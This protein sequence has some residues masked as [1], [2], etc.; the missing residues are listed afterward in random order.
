M[1][2]IKTKLHWS[3]DINQEIQKD[4][5]FEKEVDDIFKRYLKCDWG[6][7]P[8]EDKESNRLA[9]EDG[10]RLFASCNTSKGDVFIITEA[11]PHRHITT[12]LFDHEY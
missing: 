5:K 2:G 3:C 10:S 4:T 8:E 12:I 9:I 6:D 1:K 11:E 7:L